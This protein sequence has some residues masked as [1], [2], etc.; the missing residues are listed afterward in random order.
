MGAGRSEVRGQSREA[1]ADKHM[2]QM[3]RTA[4]HVSPHIFKHVFAGSAQPSQL[5]GANA[6]VSSQLTGND[7]IQGRSQDSV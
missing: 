3:K 2:D 5:V 4:N 1:S 6:N 7:S